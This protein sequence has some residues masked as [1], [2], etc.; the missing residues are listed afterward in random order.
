MEVI[1]GDC[2]PRLMAAEDGF[3]VVHLQ[4]SKVSA[5]RVMDVIWS[6]MQG[7]TIRML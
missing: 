6:R 2:D 3:F 1:D 7:V 5:F 4:S